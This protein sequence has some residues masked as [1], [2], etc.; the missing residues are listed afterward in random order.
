[1]CS[2]DRFSLPSDRRWGV[3]RR[4]RAQG[5]AKRGSLRMSRPSVDKTQTSIHPD[6]LRRA[7]AMPSRSLT[8]RNLVRHIFEHGNYEYWTMLRCIQISEAGLGMCLCSTLSY[9][10]LAWANPL[11]TFITRWLSRSTAL[12]STR[13]RK[14][15]GVC[16]RRIRRT[17]RGKSGDCRILVPPPGFSC[18]SFSPKWPV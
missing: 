16:E 5:C 15:L 13:I 7:L 6:V 2:R 3:G 8:Y 10:I 14:H 17:V 12:L 9:G 11:W 18:K 4:R 1:M